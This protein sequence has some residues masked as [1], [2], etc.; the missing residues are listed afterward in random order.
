M[1]LSLAR[2]GKR[3]FNI[4][5]VFLFCLAVCA[6]FFVPLM[7]KITARIDS[8]RETYERLLRDQTGLEVRYTSFSP[9]LFFAARVKSLEIFDAESGKKIA[10][11]KKASLSYNMWDI[12]AGYFDSA[13][14]KL[15]LRGVEFDA[16]ALAHSGALQK[17]IALSRPADGTD[18]A[19]RFA[20][21]FDIDIKSASVF[22]GA[23]IPADCAV[24]VKSLVLARSKSNYTKV[25]ARGNADIV[26][27]A[28]VIQKIPA[29][30]RDEAERCALAWTVSGLISPALLNS[31]VSVNFPMLKLKK[32]EFK[33]LYFF[34]E[35]LESGIRISQ[36]GSGRQIALPPIDIVCDVSIPL[37]T[38][39]VKMRANSYDPLSALHTRPAALAPLAGTRISG[40]YALTWRKSTGGADYEAQGT[41][42][43]PSHK[44]L[45]RIQS[46]FSIT[47]DLTHIRARRLNMRSDK[48]EASF[49]GGFTF[50]SLQ[51]SGQADIARFELP[52]GNEVSAE[53]YFDPLDK[54][55]LCFVPQLFLGESSFTALQLTVIPN[56]A[57]FDFSFELS[58]YSHYEYDEP[59][60]L[61]MDGSLLIKS[62][63]FAQ[64][65]VSVQN[66]FLDSILNAVSF[67]L[68]EQAASRLTAAKGVSEPYILTN[69]MFVSTDFSS[70]TYNV[71][72]SI[73]A[74]TKRDRN[75]M[76]FSVDGNNTALRVTRFDF[77]RGGQSASAEAAI[78]ASSDY[79]DFFFTADI[80]ANS[81]P[82]SFSGSVVPGVMASIT[83]SYGFAASV[84]D[85]ENGGF[86][87]NFSLGGFPAA[88]RQYIFSLSA[89][90][91]FS[92][93]PAA[94]F[95][96]HVD[97]LA[98][99]EI[100]GAIPVNPRIQLAGALNNYGFRIETIAY[101]DTVSQLNGQGSVSWAF[102]G[103]ILETAVFTLS[104]ENPL[105]PERFTAQ[106]AVSNPE[107]AEFSA[108]AMRDHFYFSAAASARGFPMARLLPNQTQN[109]TVTAEF[110]ALGTL[111]DPFVTLTVEEAVMTLVSSRLSAQ[112][113]AALED[114]NLNVSGVNAQWGA[115]YL[116]NAEAALSVK[117]YTGSARGEY[118]LDFGQKSITAPLAVD[119]VSDGPYAN[120]ETDGKEFPRTFVL[121]V[122][123]SGCVSPMF[124]APKPF[125]LR[126]VKRPG[127]FDLASTN[128]DNLAF[129]MLD[130]GELDFTLGGDLPVKMRAEGVIK[131]A[132]QA[133]VTM[134]NAD[135]SVSGINIDVS[136]FSAFLD[137][138]FLA[139]HKGII[140]GDIHIGGL[141]SDPDFDGSLSLSNIEISSPSYAPAHFTSEF[142]PASVTENTLAIQNAALQSGNSG[143]L[144]LDLELEL[145]RWAFDSVRLRFITPERTTAPVNMKFDRITARGDVGANVEIDIRRGAVQV[146][147]AVLGQNG[148]L[149]VTMTDLNTDALFDFAPRNAPPVQSGT[150]DV[151]VNLRILVGSRMQVLINAAQGTDPGIGLRGL[152][153]QGT[154]ARLLIDTVTDTFIIQGDVVLRGGEIVYFNRNF[155]LREGRI[156]FNETFGV[157]D[158]RI[159][160]RA[161]TR[162]RDS[163]GAQVR[164]I[165]TAS[166]QRLSQFTPVFTA[167]PAKS[168]AEIMQILGQIVTGDSETV[169]DLVF[170]IVDWGVQMTVLR[171]IENGLR[172]LLNF[173]IFSMRTMIVQNALRAQLDTQREDKPIAA[174]SLFDNSSVYAGK[175]FGSSIYADA[176]L[177][178]SY[179]ENEVLSGKSETG[180]AFQPEFGLEMMSPY[181]TIRWSIAPELG[182]T[183]FLWV[184]AT[185]ITLSWKFN[186]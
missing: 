32:T 103:G 91:G 15:S 82:Y 10:S 129:W 125:S 34:A 84:Y 178:I 33:K 64:T 148:A 42:T 60:M 138:N 166:N 114:G 182:K 150:A 22:T 134:S 19:A 156:V 45:G 23:L 140:T 184:D 162:D 185:S 126:A 151:N 173:D 95:E 31:A 142:V 111:A 9:S 80:V 136:A 39:S 44:L 154:E 35:Y 3:F 102:N 53:I 6:L 14:K 155:Y 164:I 27:A 161:E 12:L 24:S 73:I 30:F 5:A 43:L 29:R 168:E 54:G 67:F 13:F 79:S 41:V 93:S 147:G 177:H 127:R 139:A 152:V 99:T 116:R 89:D 171:K 17:L 66:F 46:N 179:D 96:A 120:P 7:S 47:G 62:P 49:A 61:K 157:F 51:P 59:G 78:D 119:F 77:A 48:L 20:L 88:W 145:D 169:G 37:E 105:G 149:E 98:A 72:Y 172:E 107:R 57:S 83:G 143:R 92:W 87:G 58:D 170:G 63:A 153:S 90:I 123:S 132:A 97:S 110:S 86:T 175:Y 71:P 137:F 121:N 11:I 52:N 106:A 100:N 130:S 36:I 108:A 109:D 181:V 50:K 65:Y 74:N 163:D 68:P 40:D 128:T 81:I 146:S 112:G 85:S 56:G 133:S 122:S 124:R 141:L 38:V 70:F 69:E 76:L 75:F 115:H 26:P 186:F 183:D 180:M 25:T 160:L 167:S 144:S 8:E 135:I 104:A 158:P 4:I 2:A 28:D 16:E 118:F 174:G 1:K 55:F 176:L 131:R 113:N 101:S 94:G 159:T 18:G 21:P 165:M 117:D